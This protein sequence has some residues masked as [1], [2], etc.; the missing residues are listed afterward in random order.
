[1]NYTELYNQKKTDLG[2]CLSQ[3]QSGDIIAFAGDCNGAVEIL[4]NMHTI[5]DRVEG[6]ECIKGHEGNYPFVELPGMNGHINTGGFFFGRNFMRGQEQGNVSYIVTDLC[7]YANFIVAHK[8]YNV[9]IAAASPMDENGN[10]QVSLCLMWEKETLECVLSQPEHKIILEVNPNLPRVR[11]GID[12]NIQDVTCL[13]EV[14]YEIQTIP[15]AVPSEDELKVAQNVRS[16]MRD[17]DCIQLGIGALPDA[18]ATQC[19]DLK[20]LGLHTEMATTT[21][22]EMI[23]RGVITSE[24]KN[25]NKGEHIFTFAGGDLALYDTLSQDKK[26]R[27]V[28]ASYGVNPVNIMQN[29]NMVSINTCIEMD[30]TGQVCSESI[31]PKQFSGSGGGFCYAYG[32]L[33]SK[34]GRGIMAFTSITKKGY[35]KIKTMLTEGANVTVP[36]NYVDYIV[37]EY[38]IA[39][40]RGRSVKERVEALVAIAHPDFRADLLRDAR[41]LMYI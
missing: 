32:A 4:S 38:G 24:R 30:L 15:V 31:G 22:G 16:L 19:F 33:H 10:F 3:I 12:I 14:D 36:R 27:I 21:M 9:Y 39:H 25:F 2:G 40:L 5:A 17:G 1:M 26:C 23:R 37:T 8:P 20:D 35:S 28:P 29:D 6:V 7:D 34:G 11:G 13:M 18:I 41:K